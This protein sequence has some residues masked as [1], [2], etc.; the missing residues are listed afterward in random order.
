MD[1][2]NIMSDSPIMFWSSIEI[3]DETS[4]NFEV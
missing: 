1:L 2:V 4:G 3:L